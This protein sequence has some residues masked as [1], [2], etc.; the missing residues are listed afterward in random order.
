M[1]VIQV[2]GT[3]D[4]STEDKLQAITKEL[5]ELCRN[6]IPNAYPKPKGEDGYVVF[7]VDRMQMDLG[8][9]L[10]ALISG[11]DQEKYEDDRLEWQ[12]SVAV[13]RILRKHFPPG[14]RIGVQVLRGAVTTIE[15]DDPD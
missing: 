7:G 12:F 3:S 2:C 15:F 14:A 1:I 5:L 11:F 6:I 4:A 8:T 13:R 9:E 10:I